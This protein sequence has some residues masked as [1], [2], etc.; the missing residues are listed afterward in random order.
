MVNLP[1]KYPAA[2]QAAQPRPHL[3]GGGTFDHVEKL[4]LHTTETAGWP[5]YPDFAPHLTY[6]PWTHVW[7]Q[8]FP[9]TR[10][11]TTLVDGASTSVRENRDFCIQIEIVAYCD[12]AMVKKYGHGI[13]DIDAEAVQDLAELAAWLTRYGLE[14]RLAS[15]W[16]PY[17]KSYGNTRNRMSGPAYD[18]FRGILGH[19][20]VSTNVHGD[21]GDPPWLSRMLTAAKTAAGHTD[22]TPVPPTTTGKAL[23]MSTSK[24]IPSAKYNGKQPLVPGTKQDVFLGLDNAKTFV[25]GPSDGVDARAVFEVK[26]AATGAHVDVPELRAYFVVVSYKKGTATTDVKATL[27]T[28]GDTVLYAGDLDDLKDRTA[29]LRLRLDVP[30]TCPQGLVIDWVQPSGW[31]LDT[32]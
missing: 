6:N 13:D 26:D 32:K 19:E 4:V 1:E 7:H 12:P 25:I 31:Y 14:L 20:H 9:L 10:S 5:G 30:D 28:G 22:P 27:S 21:P 2:N 18:A 8:H 17:P 23:D 15:G 29:R 11:A 16:L 24:A 3:A